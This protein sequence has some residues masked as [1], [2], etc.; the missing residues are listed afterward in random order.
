MSK[1]VQTAWLL[2]LITIVSGCQTDSRQQ[3]LATD[4]SQ[5][6]LRSIQTRVFDTADQVLTVRTVISTLQDLGFTIDKVDQ[7]VGVV[8]ATKAGNYLMK[9]T[10]S[11]RARGSEQV[12]VRASAQY[13]LNA[14]ND[15]SLY[16]KFFDA[17]AQA[18]FLE[19]NKIH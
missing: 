2:V 14:V 6:A 15:S 18:M 9:M 1:N 5:V 11:T 13:N 16:Q 3:I 4:K 19:A 12:F 8:S 17:L 10:I 7:E